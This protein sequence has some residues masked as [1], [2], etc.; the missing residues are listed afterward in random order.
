VSLSPEVTKRTAELQ[1]VADV[2]VTVAMSKRHQ[3]H[4][5]SDVRVFAENSTGAGAKLV[6]LSPEVTKPKMV[7]RVE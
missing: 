1:A 7:D 2:L 6:S 3:K 5:D 4:N